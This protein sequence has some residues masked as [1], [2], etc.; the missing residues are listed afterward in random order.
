MSEFSLLTLLAGALGLIAIGIGGLVLSRNLF[1][2]V[3][4]LSLAEAGANLLLVLVGFRRDAIAPII[5]P[6]RALI[7]M[8]DPIPQAMVLTAIVIG[9]GVQALA[10]SLA[11]RARAAYGTL[12]MN[13]MRSRMEADIDDA[14]GAQSA[15]SQHGPAGGRPLPPVSAPGSAPARLVYAKGPQA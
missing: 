4:A 8:V 3:L 11:I 13:A 6:G 15:T 12:D 2:I 5:E 10:L 14:A 9:V 7:S 1:R